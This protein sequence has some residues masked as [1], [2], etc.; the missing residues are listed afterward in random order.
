MMA[1]VPSA[2]LSFGSAPL[3]SS[4]RISGTSAVFAAIRKG[5]EPMRFNMLRLP[6]RG[7]LVM[8]AFTFAPRATSFFTSSRLSRLP[9]GTAPGRLNPRFG[10]RDQAIWCRAVHP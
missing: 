10:R 3:S 1:D 6:S 2:V 7:S 4:A 8:R 9:V 5:V